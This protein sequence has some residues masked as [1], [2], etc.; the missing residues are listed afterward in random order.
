MFW[1]DRLCFEKRGCWRGQ[2]KSPTSMYQRA[3]VNQCCR[4]PRNLFLRRRFWPSIPSLGP[5]SLGGRFFFGQAPTERPQP[6]VTPAAACCARILSEGCLWALSDGG[7]TFVGLGH[8][9]NAGPAEN[10]R[11]F[12]SFLCLFVPLL[13]CMS[14]SLKLKTN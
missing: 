6:V 7:G 8:G 1:N 5:E 9:G 14:P 2:Y 12:M 4:Y 11:A 10:N 3:V 13:G